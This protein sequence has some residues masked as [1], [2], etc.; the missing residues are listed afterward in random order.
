MDLT[1]IG[2]MLLLLAGILAVFGLALVLAGRGLVPRLPGDFSF[3]S[4]HFRVFIPLGTSILISIVVTVLL[5]VFLR[6]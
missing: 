6:R 1:G 4:G 3:G 5:N 2:K